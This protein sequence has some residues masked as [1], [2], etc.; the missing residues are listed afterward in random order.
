MFLIVALLGVAAATH[1]GRETAAAI[2]DYRI[3][4]GNTHSHTLYTRSH[5]E[6]IDRHGCK[7]IQVYGPSA[8]GV[9]GWKAG[10]RP[11]AGSCYAMYVVNGYQYPSPN[12]G[13]KPTWRALQGPPKTHF[14]LARDAGYDWYVTT[15][16]SQEPG[17]FPPSPLNPQWLASKR[18]ASMATEF[19]FVGLAGFEYSENDGPDGT[20]HIN[21]INSDGIVNAL[22][23]G[24]GFKQFYAWL[25][26]ATANGAGPVVASFNHPDATSYGG[27]GGRTAALTDIV[28]MLE[29]VNSDTHIHEAGFIAALDAGWKVS[30]VSGLDNHGL[31]A[32]P[33][34]QSRTFLLA[35]AD[36]KTALLQAMRQRRTY[37][38]LD[39][40]IECRYTVN[41]RIMGSILAPTRN[42]RFAIDVRD[43]DADD[44]GARIIGADIVTDG[45][46]VVATIQPK[47]ATN[48]LHWTPTI[49]DAGAHYYYV[50]IW[51]A[52]H[53]SAA[54]AAKRSPVAWLAPVW[55]GRSQITKP[56]PSAGATL[57]TQASGSE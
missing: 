3:Y 22:T 11:S 27:F 54:E 33:T 5:G 49:I 56:L 47:D 18:A 21:V 30:P 9:E 26:R 46:H 36:T 19:G 12:V 23:P 16:H 50:R 29:V 20:G 1:Q 17:F 24:F 45:G 38:A 10:Y 48:V 42:Y 25:A 6:M 14:R 32:I 31:G 39:R 52:L 35:R 8:A 7:G 28:T 51:N 53:G 34:A 55:T 37:A 15:D 4:A 57:A 43:P 40:D 41:G 13:L 44:P 2:T